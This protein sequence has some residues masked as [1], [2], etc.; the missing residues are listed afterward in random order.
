MIDI[1][2]QAI[3]HFQKRDYKSSEDILLKLKEEDENN[4][5]VLYFLAVVKSKLGDFV[6]AIPLFEEVVKIKREHTEA[7]YNLALCQHNLNKNEEALKNYKKVIEL[8]PFL[9]EAHNNIAIIYKNMNKFDEAEKAFRMAVKVKPDNYSAMS[10]LSGLS[11]NKDKSKEYQEA[12]EL[13]QRK[14]FDAAKNIIIG[15]LRKAPDNLHLLKSLGIINYNLNEFKES[16]ECYKKIIELNENNSEAQYSLGVCYQGLDNNDL[17]LKHYKKAIE[18]NPEYLDAYNN[19]GLL[20]SSLKN[21]DEAEKCFET[22]L[23]YKPAYF[24]SIINLGTIKLHRDEYDKALDYFNEA[25]KISV[26]EKNIASKSVAYCNIGFVHLRRKNLD[27]AIKYFN[28]GIDL[29]PESVLAHYNK[30]EVLLMQGQFDEGWKEY[31][32]R[33]GRKDFG[34]RKFKPFK[35]ENDLKGKRVLVYAEQGLG[36]AIQFIRYLPFLKKKGCY[37]ILECSKHLHELLYNFK[38]VDK[39]IERNLVEKPNIEYDY[40]VPLLSLPLYFK[41]NAE[42]IPA[43]VPYLS[44]NKNLQEKWADTINEDGKIKIGI[45]WAG[46]PIHTNDRHRSVRLQQFLPLLSI[47]GTHYYSLQKGFQVMQARDYQLL[48]TELDE[49][50]RSFAD[51]A[52][53]IETLDLVITIDTSVAHLAGALG[54]ETWVLLPYLPDWRWLLEG[55]RSLWYPTMK[56]YRQPKI[57][58]WDSVFL[59]LKKDLIAFVKN[60]NQN[61]S[62]VINFNDSN[63]SSNSLYLG[64]TSGDNFG[65]GVCSKYLKKE[66]SKKENIVNIDEHEELIKTGEVNGTV[67]HALN[68]QDFS[69]LHPVRGTKNI[70]Y[71][72]FEY[73]LKDAAVKNASNYDIILGGSSSNEQ[74]LKER[75]IKNTGT[76]IQGID[77]ELF[78]PEE[79]EK[80]NDLFVIFS[81]GKFELRKGQDLVL[82]AFQILQKKFP[83]M[84]LIN[85]W[86]NLWPHTMNSMA[87]SKYIKYDYKGETWKNFMV[88]LCNINNIDGNKVFTLPITPGNKLRELYLS[89]DIGLFPNRCEGG[90]NL[91]L[92]EYMAC[93]KAVIASYNSGHKDILTATNSL[94][95]KEMNEFKLFDDNNNLIADWEEPDLDE[96]IAKLEYA[97][98]NRDAIKQIGYKAG[99]YMK[100]YTWSQTTDSLIQIIKEL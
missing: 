31:E 89:S 9:S 56:L 10:N 86:Y 16:I 78:Y 71:T 93:G 75:G 46:S 27:E 59:E 72:F 8:N 98:Y 43:G 42:N 51:T 79:K 2:Q 35:P 39:I 37:I 82:R 20:Y 1:Y 11:I 50:I 83:D 23:K 62:E 63:T 70:G 80:N 45:V 96:I 48:L 99:Q 90:T 61:N 97:Y 17:A 84:I 24:N 38:Y 57:S 67:F 15:L 60:K 68:N 65:W 91:V 95:L 81:G 69:G 28:I 19:L 29:E 54:K 40:E 33:Q 49:H 41:T 53:I 32:W 73:E 74:K 12:F 4:A 47:E 88:N 22:A 34:K 21:Y 30:A 6:S 100:N 76:L 64:L 52:A 3:E 7:Y 94:L 85:A 44:V 26:D 55:N 13:F 66:L 5:D 25:I 18:L 58:D 77:P 92:M 36:D 14:E 87:I